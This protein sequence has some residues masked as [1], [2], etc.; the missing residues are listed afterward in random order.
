MVKTYAILVV[1]NRKLEETEGFETLK[2]HKEI[3]AV[4]CDNSTTDLGN[5]EAAEANGAFY[6]DMEGNKGLS[7]AY[8]KA[9]DLIER[10][11]P[12]MA[13]VVIFMDDDTFFP[14][15]YF[16]EVEYKCAAYPAQIFL[17]VVV[18]QRGILSPFLL[19]KNRIARTNDPAAIREEELGA[20]NS[21]MAVRL[22][23]FRT[24][25][26]DERLFLD[27]IDHAFM[28]D[29][30]RQKRPMAILDAELKQDFSANSDSK[31]K[32]AA[33]FRNLA[34]D[35]AVYYGASASG[36]AAYFAMLTRRKLSLVKRFRDP[37]LL[38]L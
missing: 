28:R 3:T 26:Y 4:V 11:D 9:L 29:M 32:A 22:D 16:E 20:I 33:R 18:D 13:G 2:A 31:E 35:A 37:K 24:Y 8:N 14:E 36:R 38:F 23:V 6:I 1:Y 5:R 19:R 7:R 15:H 34:K 17:P 12:A 10:I 27:Y 30:H 21:G 25:R